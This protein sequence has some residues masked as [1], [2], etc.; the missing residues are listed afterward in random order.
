[1]ADTSLEKCQF[2]ESSINIQCLGDL[3][4]TG[5]L[6]VCRYHII[7]Y[8]V[9]NKHFRL[10]INSFV[11]LLPVIG[12]SQVDTTKKPVDTSLAKTTVDT[13]RVIV[14]TVK[15]LDCYTEYYNTARERGAKPVPDGMQQVVIALKGAENS[16]CFLGQVEVV[17]GK[18][19]PPLYFQQENGEYRLVSTVGKKLESAF[20]GSMTADEL[21]SIRDGMSIVFRTAD[22]EYGR[23]FFF[24]FI[25][26]KGAL[27]NKA[28]PSASELIKE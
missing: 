15:K 28:A 22:N 6:P 7:K 2:N 18:I 10:L 8:K 20:V 9:M 1:M 23:L 4:W 11:L 19:K 3:D 17:N 14:D 25:N 5:C 24:K 27:N 12:F 16:H 13:L 21:Y 26:G